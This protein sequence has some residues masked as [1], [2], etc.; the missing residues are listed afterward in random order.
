MLLFDIDSLTRDPSQENLYDLFN[1]TFIYDIAAESANY[2]V[3]EDEVMRIDLICYRIYES[4]DHVDFLLSYNQIDNPLNI[5]LGDVIKYVPDADF[6]MYKTNTVDNSQVVTQLVNANKSTRIDPARQKFLD[7][8][9]T[10]P[11]NFQEEPRPAVRV[12][13]NFLVIS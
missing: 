2:I 6:S 7:Q 1:K 13:D 11:P 8:G 10:L 3:Q 12:E 5:K 9:S 4:V